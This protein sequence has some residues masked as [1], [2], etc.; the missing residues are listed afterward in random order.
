MSTRRSTGSTL[1][2]DCGSYGDHLLVG[3]AETGAVLR[4]AQRVRAVEH[5]A[6]VG[7]HEG[8]KQSVL[9]FLANIKSNFLSNFLSLY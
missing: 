2:G 7:V 8:L 5:G 3:R 4:V 1:H 9:T 6:V